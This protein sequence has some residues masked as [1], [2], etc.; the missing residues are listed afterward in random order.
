MK[1]S[2][3]YSGANRFSHIYVEDRALE[4][5][6]ADILLNRFKYARIIPIK[7]YKNVF[8]RP[9]QNF[10]LQKNYQNIIL[11]VKDEPFLYEGPEI[12][13]D[14]GNRHFYYAS[15]VLNCIYDCHYCYLQGMYQSANIVIFVN[16]EDFFKAVD[17]KLSL[18]GSM[19]LCTSY[20]TDLLALEGIL[21]YSRKWI[22]FASSREELIMEIRTKSANYG[23]I[24]DLAP[25]PNVILAWT[26]S[27]DEIIQKYEKG[28]PSLDARIDAICK[29]IDDGWNVRLSLEPLIEING[30]ESIYKDFIDKVCTTLPMDKIYDVN[31]GVFRMNRE[32]FKKIG[33]NRF[34]TDIFSHQMDVDDGVVYYK[35]ENDM[36]VAVAKELFKYLPSKKIY[37]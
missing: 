28:T 21:P 14:F 36:E 12:C 31:V 2:K 4:Y 5:D 19:Y 17:R 35:N 8:N 23:K 6:V 15:A 1:N 24:S 29:A 33:K 18:L 7:H 34:D 26:L 9:R 16:I 22:E 20:D 37:V 32:Y 11:A 10:W 3:K 27:P 30:W 13:E 25:C